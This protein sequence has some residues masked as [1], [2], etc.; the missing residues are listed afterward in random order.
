MFFVTIFAEKINNFYK[1][2]MMKQL[3]ILLVAIVLASCTQTKIAYINV[4]TVMD[5]YEGAKALEA[6]FTAQQQEMSAELQAL[7]AP[8]QAKVQE[9]YQGADKMTAA[10]RAEVEQGL[11][12]EQQMIQAKQQQLQQQLQ[13][14]NQ[15]KS[16]KLIKTLD[17]LVADYSKAKGFNIVLATQ[18]NGTVMYG[19][20]SLNVTADVIEVL[21]ASYEVE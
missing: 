17:S 5:E 11:Q 1:L 15:V 18:G 21:N 2:K 12:Q 4:E 9:Y 16:E 6:E 20:E 13:Q 19:D 10:Q 8:F 3:L 7:Q 14:E